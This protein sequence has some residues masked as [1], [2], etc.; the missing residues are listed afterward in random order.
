MKPEL[1]SDFHPWFSVQD[2]AG[3][4]SNRSR[5]ND[6]LTTGSHIIRRTKG[7][8]LGELGK[9]CDRTRVYFWS[10]FYYQVP[11]T[12]VIFIPKVWI[13]LRWTALCVK[14]HAF[15]SQVTVFIYSNNLSGV[16]IGDTFLLLFLEFFFPFQ[17]YL[18]IFQLDQWGSNKYE[19]Q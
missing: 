10:S 1:L 2:W 17:Y 6:A 7:L 16:C 12:W 14:R 9:P 5:P 4:Q 11:R 13:A 19:S 3:S 18:Y 8:P 15:C